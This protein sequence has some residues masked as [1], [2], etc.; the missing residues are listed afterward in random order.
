MAKQPVYRALNPD[1]APS[2]HRL[3]QPK[4]ASDP[5]ANF[6]K[7]QGF[8]ELQECLPEAVVPY[9]VRELENGKIAYFNYELAKEMGLIPAQHPHR[10]NKQLEAKILS[11]FAIQIINEY[12]LKNKK[13][14]DSE[15]VKQYAY[16]A[17]RYLQLQHVNKKGQTSGDG[18]SVWNGQISFKGKTW[19]VS[20]RGTGVTCLAPGAVDAGKPVKTGDTSFGYGCGTA[21]L[22]ELMG[23]ALM[24]EIYHRQ[25]LRTERV[26]T[27]IDLGKGVGIGVRAAHNLLRPAHMFSFLKQEKREPLQRAADYLIKRQYK[28]KEWPVSLNASS[29]YDK[30]LMEV[31]KSFAEFVAWLE[32]NY[33]FVW[34]DWDG[35]NVLANAGIID[36]GSVRQFGLCHNFYRYDDVDRF[37][38]SLP[39]QKYKAR[40]TVQVFAQLVDFLNTGRKKPV[41]KYKKSPALRYFDEV[42]VSTYDRLFLWRMGFDETQSAYLIQNHPEGFAQFKKSFHYFENKKTQKKVEKLPDGINKNPIFNM[43]SFL[44]EYPVLLAENG[45]QIYP[46]EEIFHLLL[47]GSATGRDTQFKKSY[48]KPL[49]QLQALYMELLLSL[50]GSLLKN[51]EAIKTR[52]ASIN[53]ANRITGNSIECTVEE[54]LKAR[55]K[56]LSYSEIQKVME[57][58]IQNQSLSDRVPTP[59]LRLFSDERSKRLLDKVLNLV[60]HYSEDI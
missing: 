14:F 35:D 49:E 17:T 45:V 27:I 29:K 30:M 40:E 44:R 58:F 47:A 52:S 21:D 48:N 7:I 53:K 42:F 31:S 38:T 15:K 25:G 24:S 59:V 23:S 19:D 6:Q 8:H 1:L 43:R 16:M 46:V 22:D 41:G 37:S 51:V 39:E 11:T 56:G 36:Y 54:L 12:D 33:M 60:S 50:P 10:L 4:P 34:L 9:K 28:N 20:S 55:R 3:P 13:K 57:I 32:I 26:L 18:R 5:Y 2:T